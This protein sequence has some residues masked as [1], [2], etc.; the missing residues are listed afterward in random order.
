MVSIRAR[1]CGVHVA[2]VQ[3][4]RSRNNY[5]AGNC[6]NYPRDEQ[7]YQFDERNELMQWNLLTATLAANAAFSGLSGVV[8]TF[9]AVPLA[10]WLGIPIWVSVVIGLGLLA[11]SVQVAATTRSPQVGAVRLVIAGDL[12]WVVSAIGLIVWFPE[13]MSDEGI[14]ALGLVTVGV[15]VFATLQWLGLAIEMRGELSAD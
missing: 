11:F 10:D 15:G 13:S 5:L 8:L 3:G 6:P 4:D 9:A 12:A 2:T 7:W 14:F 1:C